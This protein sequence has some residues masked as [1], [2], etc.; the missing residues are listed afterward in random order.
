M[1]TYSAHIEPGLRCPPRL[2]KLNAELVA[3]INDWHFPMV[4]DTHRND[5]F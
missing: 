1:D 4:N 3:D 2:A 5:F